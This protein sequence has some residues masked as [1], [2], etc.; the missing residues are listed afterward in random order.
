MCDPPF[1]SNYADTPCLP[2]ANAQSI[3]SPSTSY[4]DAVPLRRTVPERQQEVTVNMPNHAMSP[5][6]VNRVEQKRFRLKFERQPWQW[7]RDYGLSCFITDAQCKYWETTQI[8]VKTAYIHTLS[9]SPV[10]SP[11]DK[12]IVQAQVEFWANRI[13]CPYGQLYIYIQWGAAEIKLQRSGTWSGAARPARRLCYRP[14]LT[15]SHTH[16]TALACPQRKIRRRFKKMLFCFIS[17]KL[18][19]WNCLKSRWGGGGCLV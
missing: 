1:L 16:L 3:Y 14:A 15:F 6:K 9:N 7:Y 13:E 5:R 18:S 12:S 17:L 8:S 4:L 10:T 2:P 19:A 11:F